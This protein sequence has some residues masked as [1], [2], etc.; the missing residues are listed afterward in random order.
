MNE[1]EVTLSS[2][3]TVEDEI[4]ARELARIIEDFLETLTAESRVVFMLRY[5]YSEPYADIAKRVGLTEKN[6]S[7]RL[8]RI[9]QRMKL[10][11][12]EREVFV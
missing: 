5:A 11:L 2:P 12:V 4:E 1:L 10:Y 9:R 8:S 6:V 3:N 7:V